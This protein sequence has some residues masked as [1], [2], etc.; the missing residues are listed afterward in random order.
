MLLHLC[1]KFYIIIIIV[2]QTIREKKIITF[3]GCLIYMALYSED[4]YYYSALLKLAVLI[5]I[6]NQVIYQVRIIKIRFEFNNTFF[7]RKLGGIY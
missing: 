2:T 7:G 3:D 5:K 4:Y 6:L 1:A